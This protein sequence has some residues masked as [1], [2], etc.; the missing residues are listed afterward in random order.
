MPDWR[1][2]LTRSERRRLSLDSPGSPARRDNGAMKRLLPRLASTSLALLCL[3]AVAMPVRAEKRT[4][5]PERGEGRAERRGYANPSAVIAAE[6][7][8]TRNVAARGSPAALL[9]AAAPDAVV[10]APQLSWAHDWLKTHATAVPA[11]R[12][13]PYAVWSSCDGSLVAARGAWLV[14]GQPAGWFVRLWQRQPDGAYKWVIGQE[15]R[16]GQVPVEPEMIAASV[17][18]CP[19]RT[20]RGGGDGPD[21]KPPKPEKSVKRRDLPPLDPLHRTGGARDGTVRWEAAIGPDGNP[22]LSVT[23]RKDGAEQAL[24]PLT[25]GAPR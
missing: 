17:A 14:P 22:R 13:V 19:V 11:A 1:S 9:A 12:W 25:A 6:L 7:A 2:R 21:R 16:T 18:D 15:G 4:D 10:F 8:L 3:A 20:G 5:A 23:W 24:P